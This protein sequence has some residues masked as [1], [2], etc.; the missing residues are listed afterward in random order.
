[1]ANINPISTSMRLTLSLGEVDGKAVEKSVNISKLDNAISVE[2]S[3]LSQ[4]LSL[5]FSNIPL[6]Q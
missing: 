2:N 3:L 6:L 1:M 4:T 5:N